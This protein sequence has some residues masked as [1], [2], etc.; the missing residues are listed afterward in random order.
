M[1][2]TKYLEISIVAFA[3][4][5]MLGFISP[6]VAQT[7][8]AKGGVAAQHQLDLAA[9]RA[10]RKAIVGANM[11]LNAQEAKAFWPLYDKYEAKMDK[12]EDRH[13]REIKEYADNYDTLTN[14]DATRK[15]DEVMSIR[16]ADLD[17]Q[18]E[19]IPKFR[20]ALSAVQ[21]T[22]FFQIDSKLRAMVQCQIAR[23]VPLAHPSAQGEPES[24]GQSN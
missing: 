24:T 1:K 18:K 12:I 2:L 15:L 8:P 22:R 19:F 7:A 10:E 23:M 14:N 21:V 5:C 16:Q 9:A 3:A 6:V 11:H 20:A 13:A 17:T 4:C